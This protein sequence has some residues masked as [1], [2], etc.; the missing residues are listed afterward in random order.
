MTPQIIYQQKIIR[1]LIIHISCFSF[2][3]DL[4]LICNNKSGNKN[5][6]KKQQ[7]Q[8]EPIGKILLIPN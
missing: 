4:V 5:N 2:I 6:N 8:H 7:Q 1:Q 3:F